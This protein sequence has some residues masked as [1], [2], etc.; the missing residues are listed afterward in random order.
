MIIVTKVKLDRAGRPYW[1]SMLMT[2]EE[3]K[4]NCVLEVTAP[5]TFPMVLN[6]DFKETYE[7]VTMRMLTEIMKENDQQTLRRMLIN[8]NI[9]PGNN[10]I[11]S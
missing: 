5:K 4:G 9:V 10:P 7:N 11:K 6:K 3:V 1:S 2:D 8:G